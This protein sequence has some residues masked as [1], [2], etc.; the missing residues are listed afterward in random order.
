MKKLIGWTDAYT[1]PYETAPFTEERKQALIECIRQRQYNFQHFAHEMLPYGTP[2]YE[3]GVHCI[4][5]KA[6][7]DDMMK[8]AYFEI[9]RGPRLM[10]ADILQLE[11]KDV[12]YEDEKYVPKEGE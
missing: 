7:W 12:L 10:P 4:L 11:A 5:T 3:D 8:E 6:Q 1:T 9:K 2:F